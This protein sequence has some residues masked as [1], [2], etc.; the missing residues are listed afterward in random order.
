LGRLYFKTNEDL[1][2]DGQTITHTTQ[3]SIEKHFE[4]TKNAL[5][6]RAMYPAQYC[7]HALIKLLLKAK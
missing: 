5:N 1:G 6:H 7:E 4:T 2:K 3:G